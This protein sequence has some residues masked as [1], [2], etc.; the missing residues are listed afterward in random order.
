[1]S[2]VTVVTPA[3]PARQRNGMLARAEAS[4]A[5]QTLQP[6]RHLVVV[7]EEQQ[8]AAAT[9]QRGLE[10]VDTEWVAFLDSDDELDTTHLEQLLACAQNTGADYVYPWFRVVG[11]SDPFPTFYRRPWDDEQ[12]HQTTITV[13]VRTGLAQMVGFHE[14]PPDSTVGGHRGGEDWHFTLGCLAAGARIVHH[15]QRTWTWH[16]HGQNSSGQPGLGDARRR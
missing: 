16:H 9:R 8:G 7:D 3:H 14:P 11:G 4:V 6:A 1:L 13:L 12:P 2:S 10:Q 5:A 15:P